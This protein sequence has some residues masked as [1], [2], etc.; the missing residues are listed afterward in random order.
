MAD[1]L[2]DDANSGICPCPRNRNRRLGETAGEN[3]RDGGR[4]MAADAFDGRNI[5]VHS[6]ARCRGEKQLIHGAFFIFVNL[7]STYF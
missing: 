2:V 5:N 4:A 7:L 3:D 1:G 6:D